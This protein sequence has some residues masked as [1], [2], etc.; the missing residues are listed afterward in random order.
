MFKY[1][2][3]VRPKCSICLRSHFK[4]NQL[5][6]FAQIFKHRLAGRQRL[7]GDLCKSVCLSGMSLIVLEQTSLC[8]FK[9]WWCFKSLGQQKRFQAIC[10]KPP[11]GSISAPAAFNSWRPRQEFAVNQTQDKYF[12]DLSF[13]LLRSHIGEAGLAELMRRSILIK[14]NPQLFLPPHAVIFSRQ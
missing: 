9:L 1:W 2:S 5:I 4:V 11:C 10:W 3:C 7:A 14:L 6:S 8:G 12:L 13:G